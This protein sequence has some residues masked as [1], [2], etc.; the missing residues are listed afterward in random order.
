M[1]LLQLGKFVQYVTD[2]NTEQE[3]ILDEKRHPIS[4]V[5][6]QDISLPKG[7]VRLCQMAMRSSMTLRSSL[8]SSVHRSVST[9]S[10]ML[11]KTDPTMRPQR[12]YPFACFHI[13]I[14]VSTF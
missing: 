13:A 6:S 11:A 8:A 14:D 2:E 9:S 3:A 4:P 7:N 10:K 1:I 5:L 12:P